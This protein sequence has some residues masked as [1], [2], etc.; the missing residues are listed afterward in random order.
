MPS[1]INC[2]VL[3]HGGSFV[4]LLDGERVTHYEQSLTKIIQQLD[5]FVLSSWETGNLTAVDIVEYAV[6]LL[7]SDPLYN[8]GK[9]SVFSFA[10]THVMEASIMDGIYQACGAASLI[11]NVEHPI[12]LARVVMEH[13]IHNYIAGRDS[14]E[15]LARKHGLSVVEE[16]SFFSTERRM[17]QYQATIQTNKML[18]KNAA[19]SSK[20]ILLCIS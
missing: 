13:T 6:Q 10:G 11:E 7:E 17:E 4:F 5:S 16:N 3:I 2:E 20:G 12:S 18:E 14:T 15:A 1:T 19:I 9:G 8:A